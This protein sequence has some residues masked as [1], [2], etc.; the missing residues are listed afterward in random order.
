MLINGKIYERVSRNWFDLSRFALIKFLPAVNL[1][2]FI[3]YFG[4]PKWYDKYLLKEENK[5]KSN[6]VRFQISKTL[7]RPCQVK[8]EEIII[9]KINRFCVSAYVLLA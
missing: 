4:N 3:L 7:F 5:K 1:T 9:Y 6:L 2:Y 8:V